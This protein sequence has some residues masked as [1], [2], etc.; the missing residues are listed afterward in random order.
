M[1]FRWIMT[2]TLREVFRDLYQPQRI[3]GASDKTL[4]GYDVTF[5][6][7][8]RYLGRVARLRDLNNRTVAKFQA[9]RLKNC[10]RGTVKNN[11]DCLLAIWRWAAKKNLVGEWPDLVP[12]H[13][14]TPIPR[15]LTQEEMARVWQ[16]IQAETRPVVVSCSPLVE[17]PGPVYWSPIYLGTWDAAERQGAM[18]GIKEGDIDLDEL[19]INFVAENRKGKRQNNIRPIMPDTAEAI[20]TL[21]SYYTRRSYNTLVFR[22]ALNKGLIWSRWGEIMARAGLPDTREFKFHC[23]RKSAGSHSVRIGGNAARLLGHQNPATT[24]KFYIDPRV[25]YDDRAELERR[26]RPGQVG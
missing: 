18:F 16:S 10:K 9:D 8:E 25:A 21:L 22:W 5:N 3:P 17:V 12:I 20:R 6:H 15:S 4:H 11:I 24:D 2:P 14:A 19:W 13:V 23:I 7:F 1:L 26:F